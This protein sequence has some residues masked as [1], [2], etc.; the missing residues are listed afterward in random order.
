MSYTPQG[1]F[2]IGKQLN[3]GYPGNVSRSMDT[4]ITN[5]PVQST[6]ASGIPF[7]GAVVLNPDNTYSLVGNSTTTLTTA[8]VSGTSY[9]TLAVVA[10]TAPVD[11]GDAVVLG[12][13]GQT[14]TAS[15]AAAVGA[16]TISVVS[17][18]ANA[19]YAV[20]TGVVASRVFSQ[21][22]GVAV[23]EVQQATTYF[24]ATGGIYLPG[25]PCDVLERGSVT[26]GCNYGVP[27]AGSAVYVRTVLN[28]ANVPNG[29]VGGFEAAPDPT[30]TSY[31]F[32]VPSAQWTTGYVDANG[33]AELTMV[34]R[35]K[36]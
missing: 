17:F 30:Q 19:A 32:V 14:V 27:S 28:T 13:G 16:T 9:T 35:N 15:A 10:L 21:F 6:D 2:V 7:G 24:P 23:R 22:A 36:A 29:V 26:V 11:V 31:S 34:A 18:S 25:M 8:L 20:G 5:R 33:V 1:G 3:N 4:I 12:A